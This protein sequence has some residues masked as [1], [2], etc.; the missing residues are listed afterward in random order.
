MLAGQSAAALQ[1]SALTSDPQNQKSKVQS[2][3]WE[4]ESKFTGF[5]L[6][7]S[8]TR[9]FQCQ[10]DHPRFSVPRRTFDRANTSALYI[11]ELSVHV[12]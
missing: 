2:V 6:Q 12:G 5:S 11:Q 3:T 10:V 8:L 4:R 9:P 7:Q 1:L